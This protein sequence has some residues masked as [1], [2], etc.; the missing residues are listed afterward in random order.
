[1]M[2]KVM[3]GIEQM[4][5]KY[6]VLLAVESRYLFEVAIFTC[7]SFYRMNEFIL[8]KSEYSGC[9]SVSKL[10]EMFLMSKEYELV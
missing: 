7:E 4:H 10:Q 3:R 9:A 1:M 5:S 8:F 6:I 2:Y